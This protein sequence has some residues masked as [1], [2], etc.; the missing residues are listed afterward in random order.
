ML[1]PLSDLEFLIEREMALA[2]RYRRPFALALLASQ[3]PG[4]LPSPGA[5]TAR[6]TDIH[7]D[8]GECQCAILMPNTDSQAAQAALER[9]QAAASFGA[10][11]RS[12]LCFYPADGQRHPSAF[13]PVLRQRLDAPTAW[14]PA[15]DRAPAVGE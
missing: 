11:L 2:D 15:A 7:F 6:S 10:A 5:Q 9:Y 4:E 8:L 12:A 1:R 13:M 3:A 14:R